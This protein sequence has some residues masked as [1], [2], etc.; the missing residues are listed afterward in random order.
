[1]ADEA[2]TPAK[3]AGGTA[4]RSLTARTNSGAVVTTLVDAITVRAGDNVEFVEQSGGLTISA[5]GPEG[6]ISSVSSNQTLDG[7]GTA[8]DPLRLAPDAVTSANIFD[9]EV[10]SDDIGVGAVTEG[11]ILDGA[12]SAA[13]INDQAAVKSLNTITGAVSLISSDE[14]LNLSSSP[15]TAR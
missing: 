4:V 11:K 10:K 9:G 7:N 13:K 5:A 3:L 15:P 12:V 6:G 1:M 8:S 2:V 14:S